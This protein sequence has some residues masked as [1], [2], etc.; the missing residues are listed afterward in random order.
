MFNQFLKISIL[1]ILI[2]LQ[3]FSSFSQ[4]KRKIIKY[5]EIIEKDTAK[6]KKEVLEQKKPTFCDCNHDLE[7]DQGTKLMYD[8]SC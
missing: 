7:Y 8:K 5:G 4:N 2:S 1:L 3:T 6:Q